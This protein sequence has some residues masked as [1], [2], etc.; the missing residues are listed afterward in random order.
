MEA[1]FIRIKAIALMVSSL[2]VTYLNFKQWSA[3]DNGLLHTTQELNLKNKIL[4]NLRVQT[5]RDMVLSFFVSTFMS[6]IF[7]EVSY[8]SCELAVNY[9]WFWKAYW[10]LISLPFFFLFS[11]SMS[12]SDKHT[13]LDKSVQERRDRSFYNMK[14][15]MYELSMIS[16]FFCSIVVSS[17][18]SPCLLSIPSSF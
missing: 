9:F 16:I 5:D 14:E 13:S 10:K 17:R 1:P 4:L 18:L 7:F 11:V 6:W 12:T 8:N 3:Y 2:T 15:N